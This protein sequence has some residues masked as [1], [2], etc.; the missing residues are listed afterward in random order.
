M[1]HQP[2]LRILVA[3]DDRVIALHM[4]RELERQGHQTVHARN[5][6]E[7]I[8]ALNDQFFDI[9]LMDIEMPEMGG[10]EATRTIRSGQSNYAMVPIIGVSANQAQIAGE[11]CKDAGMNYFIPK[12]FSIP[13]FELALFQTRSRSD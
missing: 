7:A 6:K 11:Q 12:P 3:D 4:C 8:N 10:L 13:L 1:P 5:G 2:L 9:V